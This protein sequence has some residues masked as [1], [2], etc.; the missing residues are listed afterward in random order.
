MLP[1]SWKETNWKTFHSYVN[2]NY[3]VGHFPSSY[4]RLSFTT[5][6][7]LD[8]LPSSRWK[9]IGSSSVGPYTELLWR[10]LSQT[11]SSW[12]PWNWHE[13]YRIAV[14]FPTHTLLPWNI[15][16]LEMLVVSHLVKKLL[17]QP[18]SLRPVWSSYIYMFVY[19]RLYMFRF[20]AN[21]LQKVHQ[22]CKGNYHYMIHK[23]IKLVPTDFHVQVK[24]WHLRQQ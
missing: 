22:H 10:S 20:L 9:W 23:Y 6:W 21:H 13:I 18:H 14:N 16:L 11:A 1:W 4:L 19:I 2:I 15:I 12:T 3:Y 7:K 24:M 8:S 5:L 17:K